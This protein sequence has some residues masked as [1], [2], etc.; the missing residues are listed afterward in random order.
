MF[1]SRIL[2]WIVLIGFLLIGGALLRSAW[3]RSGAPE[4]TDDG[5]RHVN[6]FL[7][8]TRLGFIGL[9]VSALGL[10]A[11]WAMAA[12]G[13]FAENAR[14]AR[15]KESRD[16]R[17]RRLRDAS[18][19]GWIFD[20]SNMPEKAL[21]RYT[22]VG[23]RIYR[24][25]PLG[26]DTAHALGYASLVRGDAG[27]EKAFE[28][29]LTSPVSTFN[30]LLSAAPVGSD[31]HLSL[32]YDLQ[33]TAT[34]QL[35]GQRGAVVVLKPTTGEILAMVSAPSFDPQAI[36]DDAQWKKL[37]ENDAKPLLNRTVNQ[38]YLPGS[39]F[40]MVVAAA[41]LEANLAGQKFTCAGDGFTPPGSARPIRDDKGEV[42]GAIDLARAVE[43]SCNQYF[44]QMALQL[45]S[46]RLGDVARRFGFHIEDTPEA[47]RQTRIAKNFWNADGTEL[48]VFNVAESRL[49][50]SPRVSAY[51]IALQAFGQGYTQTT[52]FQMALV[53][54]AI[55]HPNGARIAPALEAE[56]PPKELGPALTP[57]AAQALRP[58]LRAVV[59]RGTARRAFAG[60]RIP[61]AGKTGTAQV[62]AAN[63][64]LRIDA[65][66]VGFAPADDPQIAFAVVVE[67]GGY[68]GEKAAPI[69]RAVIEQAERQG[70]IRFAAPPRRR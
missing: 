15:I 50:L 38:Y 48:D 43:E 66:F 27:V 12:A 31:I 41:A 44:A 45:G 55:A 7:G 53:A 25:Y 67:G 19:R 33:R 5:L 49:V 23:G 4:A 68:G 62:G 60:C 10:H 51:D 61:T 54:A 1:F 65:W 37:L 46:Q 47:A 14:Y 69:A 18:L 35:R 59:E 2:S 56:R 29:K 40:K 28:T 39:T 64:A 70:I 36:Y 11:Y 58:M 17:E 26:A 21:A 6:R 42:H 13:P 30:S 24:T 63:G 3:R 16:Q 8:W 34:T 22:A 32:D 20:R 57:P 9:C 52:V